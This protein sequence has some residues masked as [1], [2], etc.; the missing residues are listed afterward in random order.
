LAV[1]AQTT[2]TFDFALDG[3]ACAATVDFDI[4]VTANEMTGSNLDFFTHGPVEQDLNPTA[5]RTD[6]FETG[7]DGWT[8]PSGY[9]R[10]N[11]TAA[12]GTWSVHSSNG[13]LDRND[14]ALS[15]VFRRGAGASS[16][17]IAERHD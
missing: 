14:V 5:S 17:V 7:N 3:A 13:Q 16:V 4:A 11:V 15:P 6:S 2:G 8:F 9:A 12:N 10:E 1:S